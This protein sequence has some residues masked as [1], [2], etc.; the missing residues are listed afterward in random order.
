MALPQWTDEQVFNQMAYG[1]TWP[2]LVITYAFPQDRSQIH[3]KGGEGSNFAPLTGHQQAFAKLALA[4]WNDL[5]APDIVP[6]VIGESNVAFGNTYLIEK[7][8]YAHAYYPPVGSVWFS[9]TEMSLMDPVVGDRGFSTY[10]HEIGHAL[11]LMHMGDYDGNDND[12]PSSYQDSS[13]LSVMSYYGP[14]NN[15]G[16]GEVV[17]G[18]WS[19]REDGQPYAVQTPMLNDIMVIQALYGAA[20]TRADNTVY[21]FGSTVQ[22]DTAALY[23]FTLNEHPILT[24]YDSG[25]IDTLDLSGWGS[26]SLV[27]LRPGHYSSVN[28]MT[29]NLAIA[30]DVII[31]NAVTGAGNDKI[32]GN[33]A[34]NILDGGAGFDHVYFT[35]QFSN[36]A[37]DFDLS[38]GH[39]SVHDTTGA[40]GTDT[41]VNIEFASFM[42][43][44]NNLNDL[45]PG[46]HRF[47]N[48]ETGSHFYTSNND[49]AYAIAM[50]DGFQY[51]GNAFARN[52]AMEGNDNSS[53]VYRFYN[54]QAGSHFYTADIQETIDVLRADALTYEG[55]AFRAYRDK[56]ADNVEVHRFFNTESGSHFYT[57]D[58]AEMA[59]VVELAGFAYEGV[60]FYADAV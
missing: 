31:E 26:N 2:G 57:A 37:L 55:I 34:D 47:Y 45:T 22:G 54:E 15:S 28:G 33:S 56:T 58:A 49:E 42:G 3:F 43:F 46:V 27:D 21:G 6:G 9:S 14:E 13:V 39:Y 36:Y 1:E 41:L 11:G 48:T 59:Q 29:N 53:N 51:E 50:L 8:G 52:V 4:T 16:E 24:I 20:V 30:R 40:D 19:I 60:A 32:Y 38:T 44:G 25:G 12:G 23:D 18:D 5:I 35:G 7:P 10:I 17:W